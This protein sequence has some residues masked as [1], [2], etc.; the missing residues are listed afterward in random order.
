MATIRTWRPVP[1]FLGA[2]CPSRLDAVH[3]GH[4]HVHEHQVEV[5]LGDRVECL[6][7]VDHG[8]HRMTLFGEE[9]QS[10]PLVDRI[11]FCQKDAQHLPARRAGL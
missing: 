8:E 3:F 4:L 9:V 2:D 7:A 10:H 6:A 5:F 1:C 11:I